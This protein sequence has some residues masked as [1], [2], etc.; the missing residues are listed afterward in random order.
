MEPVETWDDAASTDTLEDMN[1]SPMF[2]DMESDETSDDMK[3]TE[4]FDN[5]EPAEAVQ[6]YVGKV[7]KAI[8]A[9]TASQKQ[10]K[11]P[12]ARP[13]RVLQTYL[14]RDTQQVL[15]FV[16]TGGDHP[17]SASP[18]GH[19]ISNNDARVRIVEQQG[20]SSS[21]TVLVIDQWN[22]A[23]PSDDQISSCD[24]DD[25]QK[26]KVVIDISNQSCK[27]LMATDKTLSD[28]EDLFIDDCNTTD[29]SPSA[30]DVDSNDDDIVEDVAPMKTRTANRL[31][32]LGV[33]SNG[34]NVE[35]V[36]PMKTRSR[37]KHVSAIDVDSNDDDFE[38]VVAMPTRS[39]AKRISAIDVN[40]NNDNVVEGVAPIQTRS[41]AKRVSATDVDSN[42]DNV[43]EDTAPMQTRSGAK[44]VSIPSNNNDPLPKRSQS[45]HS[46]VTCD[47]CKMEFKSRFA[48]NYHPCKR[49]HEETGFVCKLCGEKYKNSNEFLKHYRIHEA[50][51][52]TVILSET[53]PEEQLSNQSSVKC[54]V[55]GKQFALESDFKSHPCLLERDEGYFVCKFC[56]EK[57][58]DGNEFWQHYLDHTR[59]K[60]QRCT[61][62]QQYFP[63]EELLKKHCEETNHATHVECTICEEKFRFR[64]YLQ[65]HKRLCHP[66]VPVSRTWDCANCELTFASRDELLKHRSVTHPATCSRC[67]EIF[68]SK[69][70]LIEHRRLVHPTT[71]NSSE[72][73]VR[74]PKCVKC[75]RTFA[76][77]EL[78]QEHC[79]VSKHPT[80]VQCTWCA[81][82]F[83]SHNDLQTHRRHTHLSKPACNQ[84]K[85]NF[86]TKAEL[87]AHRKSTHPKALTCHVCGDTFQS[88]VRLLIH[89]KDTHLEKTYTC[90]LCDKMFITRAALKEHQA[91]H[92]DDPNVK[93]E[94]NASD[95]KQTRVKKVYVCEKCGR[96]IKTRTGLLHHLKSHG[97]Q[98]MTCEKCGRLFHFKHSLERHMATHST[99]RPFPCLKCGFRF[100]SQ[101]SLTVHR[102]VHEE[103]RFLCDLC[104][105]KFTDLAHLHRH[106]KTH[107]KS[108]RYR[109][110]N[111][112]FHCSMCPQKFES[113]ARRLQHYDD[114][115]PIAEFR[116]VKCDSSVPSFDLLKTHF[117]EQHAGKI[118]HCCRVCGD[119][120]DD[121]QILTTHRSQNHKMPIQTSSIYNKIVC[122][123]CEK[124]FTS[125][126]QYQSHLTDE[127]CKA[128]AANN[129]RE[130]TPAKC[131]SCNEEF[132]T[133]A[134]MM[135]HMAAHGAPFP[136]PCKVCDESLGDAAEVTDHITQH[137]A[138]GTWSCVKCKLS[139]LTQ[140]GLLMHMPNHSIMDDYK[141]TTCNKVFGSSGALVRH[142]YIH[143]PE[144]SYRCERCNATY[145]HAN[146]FKAHVLSH[147][148][149]KMYEC[150]ECGKGFGVRG[151]LI[152]HLSIHVVGK[153]PDQPPPTFDCNI[154]GKVFSGRSYLTNHLRRHRGGKGTQKH[155]FV[156]SR[157]CQRGFTT[158]AHLIIHEQTHDHS[159][160][161]CPVCQKRF[162]KLSSLKLHMRTHTAESPACPICGKRF[163]HAWT[164]EK[165]MAT[166]KYE[167]SDDS[168][169]QVA[170]ENCNSKFRSRHSYLR[171]KD[172]CFD[173]FSGEICRRCGL[174]F[175]TREKYEDHVKV[176]DINQNRRTTETL[177]MSTLPT[178]QETSE[179]KFSTEVISHEEN[180]MLVADDAM[181]VVIEEVHLA[182]SSKVV[183]DDGCQVLVQN[184]LQALSNEQSLPSIH[185]GAAET[186]Q[187]LIEGQV[188]TE[189]ILDGPQGKVHVK[190]VYQTTT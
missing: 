148:G 17:S 48:Y 101:R 57:Y 78:L 179:Q 104:P 75:F 182:E 19:E 5:M 82:K 54:N 62:C 142:T 162:T 154:C 184:V 28:P 41:R 37:A 61:D 51:K 80:Q 44:R 165:H 171:H 43:V 183:A 157:G 38:D 49:G 95:V 35:V 172:K 164:V 169:Y 67:Q 53:P 177:P 7:L 69:K 10:D 86:A 111:Y 63:T 25:E 91:Q 112:I 132:P 93:R 181:E 18:A 14:P 23:E 127:K 99:E 74:G 65:E 39:R 59:L 115:H 176:C 150:A 175:P 87:A 3:P 15:M 6:Y 66:Q 117:R 55:C 188:P 126:D 189:L 134:H 70:E 84:C 125:Q 40:S 71:Q 22:R 147:D 46:P 158:H 178:I 185:E 76:T 149:R 100:A 160:L 190:L 155:N 159:D 167:A 108:K 163:I 173:G 42:D 52:E 130:T 33:G 140:Q 102:A 89:R 123:G 161:M 110:R 85:L 122:D 139:F 144:Q 45:C 103:K 121:K 106:Q 170:C 36:A 9:S 97:R 98:K 119:A 90:T 152:S 118:I 143:K 136:I 137:I 31:S 60:Q 168:T 4:T 1:L 92:L 187:A 151:A 2:D 131:T 109:V 72:N 21:S 56:G 77:P 24:S 156:C 94:I 113:P 114:V 27:L 107:G 20:E 105:M 116:C 129:E 68:S 180:G 141:C 146:Q 26:E 30:I 133:R 12:P 83:S 186:E 13:P 138:I 153:D 11:K 16:I 8:A 128:A 96:V 73:V 64:S 58:T 47:I 34:D 81:E 135:T 32:A 29:W 124:T 79:E 174:G 166:H 120:F 50:K 145:K 88:R